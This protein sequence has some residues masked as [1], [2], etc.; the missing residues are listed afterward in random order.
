MKNKKIIIVLIVIL[1]ILLA[2]ISIYLGIYF[3]KLTKPTNIIGNAI[4][5]TDSSITN[6]LNDK[7]KYYFKDTFTIDTK[8]DFNLESEEF[9]N[10]GKTDSD[11]AK[12]SKFLKNISNMDTNIVFKRDS[13]GNKQFIKI[14]EK[15]G[16]EEILDYKNLITNSTE[17]YFINKVLKNYVNNGTNNY[18]EV[19]DDDNTSLDNI[20]YLHQFIIK[21]IK[22]NIKEEYVN[23]YS[24]ND[25]INGKQKELNQISLRINNKVLHTILNDILDDLKKDEKANKILTSINKDFNKM[26]IN[27]K[28]VYLEKNESV[29][30]N[31]YT[32]KHLSKVLKYEIVYLNGDNKKAIS[33]EG[34]NTVGSIYYIENDIITYQIDSTFTDNS[35]L[36]K[37]SDSRSN[38]IG[39]L[40]IEKDNKGYYLTFTFDNNKSKYD[41][42]YSSKYLSYK[43][44][45]SYTNEKQ[46]SIKYLKNKVSIVSGTVNVIQNVS[47]DTTI[48]EDY[49]DSILSS[50]LT[51]E[52]K[53]KINKTNE[54]IKE[55][56][57]K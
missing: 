8:I 40:K 53:E 26:K 14:N 56:L 6:F 42:V 57:E 36:F 9:K 4:D 50:S 20:K 10:K 19:I 52:Q 37:I 7:E 51:K 45:K 47:K 2:A 16:N 29:T 46:L 34:D 43:K 3:T 25:N 32:S 38:E 28:T 44:N 22:N 11:Y 15:I 24:V 35:S 41:I 55:R 17:Y 12:K 39:N 33:F 30:L 54:R 13:K 27:N 5:K 18:F 49:N 31:I 21:S 48:N 1:I 23:V